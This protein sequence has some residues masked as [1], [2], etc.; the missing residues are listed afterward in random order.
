MHGWGD[1]ADRLHS[2]SRRQAWAE[3]AAE[4]PDDVLDAFSVSGDA[5]TVAAGLKARYGDVIDRISLYTP[6]DVEPSQL[7]AVTAALRT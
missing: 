5:A 6:Y 2:M 4:I 7:S 1:L 3:M